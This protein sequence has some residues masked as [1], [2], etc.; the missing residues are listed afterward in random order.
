MRYEAGLFH[1]LA[2]V[3]FTTYQSTDVSAASERRF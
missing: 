1:R 3:V 2:R